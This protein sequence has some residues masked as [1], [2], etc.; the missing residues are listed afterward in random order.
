M[1]R[2]RTVGR[3]RNGLQI[4][5]PGR[6]V[7]GL[8]EIG[9]SG[10]LSGKSIIYTHISSAS[11]R[12]KNSNNLGAVGDHLQSARTDSLSDKELP[13]VQTDSEGNS[14]QISL[15]TVGKE[16]SPLSDLLLGST[17][18][19]DSHR[20]LNVGKTGSC[21]QHTEPYPITSSEV[22]LSPP[23]P[24]S[25]SG[26]FETRKRDVH[27]AKNPVTPTSAQLEDNVVVA[28]KNLREARGVVP[29][30]FPQDLEIN[31]SAKSSELL[32]A[33]IWQRAGQPFEFIRR[34]V[35]GQPVR[36]NSL[37]YHL[38]PLT[39]QLPFGVSKCNCRYF[40]FFQL[41]LW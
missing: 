26:P 37:D 20:L 6:E 19:E 10:P 1:H 12:E 4:L 11:C 27:A 31:C 29:S 30:S 40:K 7:L 5:A 14:A 2:T 3:S 15:N 9:D 36:T 8:S 32:I 41:T 25:L 35:M 23:R 16:Q 21:R 28:T 18:D 24:D 39:F 38:D 13:V 17:P 22:P 33:P 34:Q